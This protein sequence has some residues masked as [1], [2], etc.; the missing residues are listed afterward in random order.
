ML[1]TMRYC[2]VCPSITLWYC[3]KSNK[4]GFVIT[5]LTDSPKTL[6]DCQIRFI[7]KLETVRAE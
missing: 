2:S 5:S 7:V 1:H 3:V 6:A 4:A